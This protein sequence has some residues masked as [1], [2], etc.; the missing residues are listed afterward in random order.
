MTES[1]NLDEL[2]RYLSSDESPEDCMMLPDFDGLLHGVICSPSPVASDVWIMAGLGVEPKEVPAWVINTIT[3]RYMEIAQGLA[4][5][6]QVVEPIFWQAKEGHVIAMD[7]C[8][9]FMKA[10]NLNPKEWLR[11]SESGTDGHLMTPIL[12]HMIDEQGNSIMDITQEKLD[13]ALDQAAEVIPETV[14]RIYS[15][16]K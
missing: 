14:A 7:W 6:P 4:H 3:D 2:D 13:K 10:V 8:E 12:L 9:G 5:D 11:L 15:Y 16:W 1:V